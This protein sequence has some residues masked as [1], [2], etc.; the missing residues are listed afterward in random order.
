MKTKLIAIAVF[1][2]IAIPTF[3]QTIRFAALADFGLPEQGT[4]AVAKLIKS[5]NPDFIIT[6]GDDDYTDGTFKGLDDVVGQFYREFVGNYVGNYGEGSDVNRFWPVPSDHSFG[7]DCSKPSQIQAYLDFY[8]LPDSGSEQ[9]FDGELNY[10]FRQGPV[11]FFM[12]NSMDCFQPGGSGPDS[13]LAQWVASIADTSD[14]PFKLISF[15]HTPYTSG[16]YRPGTQRMR[17]DY[18]NMGIN[19]VMA[20]HDH[21]YERF[22]IG[23]TLYFTNGLGGVDDRELKDPRQYGSQ[24]S[25]T[26]KHGAMLIE[27]NNDSMVFKFFTYDSVLI[28]SYTLLQGGPEPPATPDSLSGIGK[29]INSVELTWKLRD[30]KVERFEIERSADNVNYEYVGSVLGTKNHYIDSDLDVEHTYYYRIRAYNLGGFSAYTTSVAVTTLSRPE[31]LQGVRID[32]VSYDA[33]RFVW[34]PYADTS[35]NSIEIERRIG[36]SPRARFMKLKTISIQDTGY[37]DS[38]LKD[39]T[40]YSYRL[41]VSTDIGNSLYSDT[42]ATYTYKKPTALRE[43]HPAYPITT[44]LKQN[45]PNPFNPVTIIQY[46]IGAINKPSVHV[47]LDVYN[48]L[49]QKVA[50]LVDQKQ[51]S[52]AYSVRFDAGDLADGIYIY[53]LSTGQG[54][55]ETHKMVL[56]R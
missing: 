38:G 6:H 5:W 4:P 26:G 25:F 15:H 45:F 11:L 39:T 20:G 16:R 47:K 29:T 27:A 32:S 23:H 44:Q 9:S 28:D 30:M 36:N 2:F 48:I 46:S 21:T 54:F 17:W 49:G 52:G 42:V 19:V 55:R 41:W 31:P 18:E 43:P 22:H 34:T 40:Y 53:R 3:G 1:L 56:L 10:W 51:R 8:T 14:A 24:A 33:I 37:T 50:T 13:P 12:V 7:D 35:G